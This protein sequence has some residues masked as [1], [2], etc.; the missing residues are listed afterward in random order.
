M[1]AS[2]I[3][4]GPGLEGLLEEF[5]SRLE[6]GEAL[7]V[8]AFAAAH[9]EHAEQLRRVLPTVLVLAELGHSASAGGAAP[10]SPGADPELVS[11]VLGDFRIL[12]EVGRGGM[13][14]VYEAEQIS[15][16]RR[17][18]LKVLPFAATL[19]GRQLQR[20]Q[21]EARA[22]AQLHHTNIVPVYAV[23]C[24]RGVHYYA[25]QYIDGHSL[26]EV[27]EQLRR[28]TGEPER[29]SVEAPW[30]TEPTVDAASG[31]VVAVPAPET[32][33]PVATS[34]MPPATDAAYFR[35]VAELGVQAA[36]ALDH[37]HQ[38]GIV[39]RDIKPANLLVDEP[40]RLWVTDFG[41]AHM[42]G[43]ARMTATGEMVGTLRYM[44]P[45]QALA[46][47]VVVDHRTD[48][49]SLGATLYELLTLRA[50]FSG[51]DRQELLRQIAFEE[52]RRPQRVSKT[53]PAE[54]ETI[55]L[56]ALEKDPADR[57]ATAQELADD[58]KR[59]L[60][61]QLIRARPPTLWQRGRKWA[62]RHR[63][64]VGSAAAVLA[65]A[66][67]MFTGSV[68]WVARDRAARRA[69]NTQVVT[70]ALKEA[71][72]WQR[73]RR[74]PEALSAVRRAGGLL[75]GADVDETLRRQVL[76]RLADLELL[77][78]LENVRL[79]RMT[80]V[81]DGYF[82][83][84]G[85]DILYGQTF[86]DAGQDVEGVPAVEAGQRIRQSTVAVELAAMLDHWATIRR[87]IRGADDPS[88]RNLLWVA[89]VVDPDPWRT[90]VREALQS[91]DRQALRE[92]A[93]SKD[94]F[95]LSPAT[96]SIVGSALRND[97]EARGPA[98]VFLRE[99]QRRHANDF[100]LNLNLFHFFLTSRPPQLEESLRF[101][102][103]A[104]ALRP[105]SPGGHLNLGIALLGKGRLDEAIA[106]CR[107]AVRIKKDYAE[108]H[109]RLGVAQAHK[110]QLDEAVAEFREA[111]RIK[112]DF[113]GAHN[114]LGTALREKGQLDQAIT[115]Y[116]MAL[117]LNNESPLVHSNLGVAL[118]QKGQLDEAITE[119]RKALR[120]N[121]DFAD[122]HN[123][124]GAALYQKG[125][126]DEA[127]AE[128]HEALQIEKDSAEAHN[129]LGAALLGKGR[130]DE[131]IAECREAL[132]IKK[133]NAEAHCNLGHVL[134]EQ[135]RF[136]DA[137]V[138][139]KRG[140]E[141]GSR[142]Q[143]WPYPSAQWVQ[144]CERLVQLDRKL[145]AVLSGKQQPADV[146]ERIALARLCQMPCNKCYRAAL[147]FYEE[148]F[149]AA[150]KLTGDQPSGP[151]YNAAC[152]AALAGCGQGKDGVQLDDREQARLRQ[153]AL[154]WL[155]ADL[156][157]YRQAMEKGA[158]KVSPGVAQQ[159]GH[160]LGDADFAGVR[161]PDALARLSAGE[162]R[163]WQQLWQEV[164]ALRQSVAG[165]RP[166]QKEESP[167]KK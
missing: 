102:T 125:Q 131:A 117:R 97:K 160:W 151:R 122:A 119:Y 80:A 150:P 40:G 104:V 85:A 115:A 149:A 124:L 139:L 30:I 38:A 42:Q 67:L 140:H 46:K 108:A 145:S 74:L 59:F 2:L 121:K 56:K 11:G 50:A 73:Q 12:R 107:E 15:L 6:A 126:L 111:I 62:G 91:G 93:A 7:D 156:R 147:R 83:W 76:A 75:A 112:K 51:T 43:D 152:A 69:Q 157:A 57:Y 166:P 101:A 132:R 47:R 133:D 129:G 86:R 163:D 10:A 58:L 137:L 9:P 92:L 68:G 55:V 118:C 154:D 49:Y 48:V 35:R 45:E 136:A 128:Y 138:T 159:M 63:Y 25:M 5:A 109:D 162:R 18:A 16:G 26:A 20:F 88:W 65:A 19:D 34:T 37:A 165:P 52:P 141:L 106:E 44:S 64:L 4:P 81:Q 103:V 161:G 39:H 13:G 3:N 146:A 100:W 142:N 79:E 135:G 127:I 94:V 22:A 114:N 82:D 105:T 99:A 96:L 90:G 78:R 77:D 158:D 153:Q 24:E 144:H 23:G 33:K 143:R 28:V 66:V 116:Q 130:L 167:Q 17:V 61:G 71:D 32:L 27:I 84:E 8:E 134:R 113:A 123:N 36:E 87:D 98:E 70:G 72:D 95:R 21:N 89:R 164:D 53:I 110:G 1:S 148:A 41:L 31:Q 29:A 120:I 14:V 60:D 54:L 155:R